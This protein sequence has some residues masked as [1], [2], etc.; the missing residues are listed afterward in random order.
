MALT[1]STNMLAPGTPA[2]PFELPGVDGRIWRLR[3]FEGARA[4]VVVF[5][6]NH[7]PYAQAAE[8]RLIAIQ[9]DYAP[10][11]VRLA[12][13]N[14]ND[15]S[16]Y[17]EDDFEHMKRRAAEKGYNFPYLRDE[18]QEVARAYRAACT[19]DV[20]VFDAEQRLVCQS[21]IDD[22]WQDPEKVTR[23]DLRL[24]L[25]AVLAGQPLPFDPVPSMGCSIK[26]KGEGI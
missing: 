23:Q 24:V 4:L 3:D 25:D 1:Y 10:K 16:R 22:D 8:E 17:P 26:W 2:P 5:T 15:A 21:R 7:C 11:G 14:P 13:I 20:Y 18:T 12:A 9:R 19:P 6:C